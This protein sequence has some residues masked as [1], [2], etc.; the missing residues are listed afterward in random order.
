MYNL[1]VG[2]MS[3][4]ILKDIG[5]Y[6]GVFV[7]SDENNLISIWRNYMRIRVT[8][9]VRKPLKRRMKLKKAGDDW[10]WIDFKYERLHIFCFICG[11]LG[12]TEKQ[13]PNLYEFPHGGLEKPYGHWLKASNRRSTLNSGDR[14]LRSVLPT[15]SEKENGNSMNQAAAMQV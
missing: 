6:I 1:P 11:L 12:H 7:E 3:G 15:Q 13:C 4:K 5:N 14:W 9:D 2:F 10:L 8:I